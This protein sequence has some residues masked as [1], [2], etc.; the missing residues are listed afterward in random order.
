MRIDDRI[1]QALKQ[2]VAAA[3][4]AKEL[5]QRSGV[6]ASNISR[7]LS[8]KVRSMTDDCW[9]KLR[10]ELDLPVLH[11]EGTVTNTPE[12]REF[13]LAAM[14]RRGVADC[15]QLCRI[16]GY[17]SVHTVRRL[18]AGELNWFPDLLSAALD[19]LGCDRDALPIPARE[20]ELLSPRGL[21]RDGALLVR[22]VPVVDW[23]TAASHLAGA[24]SGQVTMKRW[25]VENT[26]TVPVPVGARRDTRAFRVHGI[27]MEPRI[28]DDD[29]VLV[30]PADSLASI[31]DNKIVVVCF[32][33][34]SDQPDRVVCKR[35]RR[36][37]DRSMLLTSDNPEGRIIPL[38]PKEVL[39]IGVVVRKI[40]EM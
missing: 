7:Y 11:A 35:F 16:A 1:M 3:G 17:D 32:T 2:A 24:E 18:F 14:S 6:S 37:S 4:G 9:E 34:R 19:A 8:G 25:D 28:V 31:P 21:Y 27:S 29:V 12:L 30:E 26:E 15:E 39:W 13:L 23:A 5:A 22:P 10:P 40:S 36:Q 20:K 38:D 33:D